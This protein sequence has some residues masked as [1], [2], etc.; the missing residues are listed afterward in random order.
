MGWFS[1]IMESTGQAPWLGE[2]NKLRAHGHSAEDAIVL[3]VRTLRYRAPFNQ[4]SDADIGDFALVLGK[5]K[6]PEVF[7]QLLWEAQK[8]GNVSL[9]RDEKELIRFVAHINVGP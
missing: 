9:L 1:R 7:T 8:V 3:A 5:C 4:L 6:R 2:Y